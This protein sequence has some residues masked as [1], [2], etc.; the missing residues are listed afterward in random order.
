M[1]RIGIVQFESVA[2]GKIRVTFDTGLTCLLYRGE[3]NTLG[4]KENGD[5]SESC[6]QQM[7]DEILTKRATKRA[8]HLLEKRDRTEKQLRDKL[9]EGEYPLACIDAAIAYVESYHYLD[10]ERYARTFVRLGQEK[11]SRNR[12]KQDLMVRGISKDIIALALDEEYE[13]EELTQIQEWLVKKHYFEKEEGEKEFQKMYAFLMR[14]GFQ[15]SDV[16]KAMKHK[17]EY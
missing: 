15:S 1:N 16:L 12:L 3:V 10:D 6:Y 2:K 8:M 11:K 13:E 7:L 4:I 5:I 17:G 9:A 14:K